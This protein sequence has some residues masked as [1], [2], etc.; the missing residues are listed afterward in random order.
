MEG[1]I[2]QLANDP[3]VDPKYRQAIQQTINFGQNYLNYKNNDGTPMYDADFAK[4]ETI[5]EFVSKICTGE[6]QITP[7]EKSAWDSLVSI[8]NKLG[9]MVGFNV[10]LN[11]DDVTVN[12][13]LEFAN[14]LNRAFRSGNE[15][16]FEDAATQLAEEDKIDVPTTAADFIGEQ[17]VYNGEKG[18]LVQDEGGKITFETES[19]IYDL[20]GTEEVEPVKRYKYDADSNTISIGDKNYR[21]L[22][23]NV[24]GSY[25]GGEI[26]FKSVNVADSNNNKKT[27]RDPELARQVYEA[28][29]ER[30]IIPSISEDVEIDSEA[31]ATEIA[32][33]ITVDNNVIVPARA[34]INASNLGSEK[35]AVTEEKFKKALIPSVS[36][37]GVVSTTIGKSGLK[38]ITAFENNFFQE[39]VDN[40]YIQFGIP[41]LDMN[42]Q[43]GLVSHPDSMMVGELRGV[44][45]DKKGKP[46]LDANKQPVIETI[47]KGSGGVYFATKDIWAFKKKSGGDAF[48]KKINNLLLIA[49]KN[50]PN[51]AV[52]FF[53]GKG[54][55]GKM[56]SNNEAPAA[57]VKIY[58]NLHRGGV[59]SDNVLKQSIEAAL[60]LSESKMDANYKSLLDEAGDNPAKIE[61]AEL[62]KKEVDKRKE[63]NK[64]KINKLISSKGLSIEDILEDVFSE[65]GS[66]EDRGSAI[67]DFL[68]KSYTYAKKEKSVDKLIEY[69][70]IKNVTKQ[71]DFMDEVSK[72]LFEEPV[73]L[74]VAKQHIYAAIKIDSPIEEYGETT[75]LIDGKEV[76]IHTTYKSHVRFQDRTKVPTLLFFDKPFLSNNAFEDLETGTVLPSKKLGYTN[77]PMSKEVKA[78]ITPSM[79]EDIR[80][81]DM[82]SA[83]KEYPSMNEDGMGNYVFYPNI[84][85]NSKA[86][87][88]EDGVVNLSVNKKEILYHGSNAKI[89]KFDGSY[90]KGGLRANYGWGI[91]FTS[92][93]YKAKEYGAETTYLDISNLNVLDLT[94]KVDEF[95]VSKIKE[96]ADRKKKEGAFYSPLLSGQYELIADKFEDHI[97]DEVFNAWRTVFSIFNFNTDKMWADILRGIGYDVSKYGYEY[98][99]FNLDK[100]D[101]YL[102]ESPESVNNHIAR[103]PFEGVYPMDTNPLGVEGETKKEIANNALKL[104]FPVVVRTT[105][106]GKVEAFSSVT[107]P[108]EPIGT[109]EFTQNK[110]RIIPSMFGTPMV[111]V[112]EP[113]EL[114]AKAVVNVQYN[115]GPVRE[116]SKFQS[117]S[118][119]KVFMEYFTPTGG[120]TIMQKE[121]MEQLTGEQSFLAN[122]I[123]ES[124]LSLRK[125]IDSFVN[126]EGKKVGLTKQTV[127]TIVNKAMDGEIDPNT[128]KP[129]LDQLPSNLADAVVNARQTI[130][131]LQEALAN[132][133]L[134]PA[135]MALTIAMSQGTYMKD[136]FAAFEVKP[137]SWLMGKITGKKNKYFKGVSEQ[138]RDKVR[139]YFVSQALLGKLDSGFNVSLADYKKNYEDP[140]FQLLAQDPTAEMAATK[141]AGIA[142]DQ[143]Y[144]ELEEKARRFAQSKIDEIEDYN[145]NGDIMFTLSG[146]PIKMTDYVEKNPNL[147]PE[148]KEYLG[149][150]VDPATSYKL[151]AMKLNRMLYSHQTMQQMK[152]D[153]LMSGDVVPST[154]ATPKGWIKLGKISQR[155]SKTMMG[156]AT[157]EVDA[158]NKYGPLKGCSVSPE[159]YQLVFNTPV[160][161]NWYY[162][163][164]ASPVKRNLAVVNIKNIIR[165]IWGY[166]YFGG[167]NGAIPEAIIYAGPLMKANKNKI[168]T[169]KEFKDWFV[170][171]FQE[172]QKRG[173]NTSIEYSEIRRMADQLGDN[174]EILNSVKKS[175]NPAFEVIKH[176]SNIVSNAPKNVSDAFGK[177]IYYGDAIPKTLMF[178]LFRNTAAYDMAA[179]TFYGLSEGQK[180]Q[181]NRIAERKV[182]ATTVTDS[183]AI[184]GADV[185]Q[186]KVGIFGTFPRFTAEAIRTFINCHYIMVN[187]K[188]LYEGETFS[189]NKDQDK[190]IKSRMNRKN[191]YVALV[192]LSFYWGAFDMIRTL[193]GLGDDD[194]DLQKV[195]I[196]SNGILEALQLIFKDDDTMTQSEALRKM[197]P[198]YDK[199]A[200][201]QFKANEDGTVSYRN[202]STADPFG[203]W[204]QAYRSILYADGPTSAATNL[205]KNVA[206]PALGLEVTFGTA[207]EI[208]NGENSKGDPIYA[209]DDLTSKQFQ[210]IAS[211]FARKTG[212]NVYSSGM[213]YRDLVRMG[214]R[215][216]GDNVVENALDYASYTFGEG[217]LGRESIIDVKKKLQAQVSKIKQDWNTDARLYSGEFY[218]TIDPKDRE[219]INE[220]R[221]EVARRNAYKLHKLVLAA[222]ALNL[223]E[224]EV[225]EV[226]K[227]SAISKKVRK[228]ALRGGEYLDRLDV[229]DIEEK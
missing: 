33:P 19:R 58:E 99:V 192:G 177:V 12:N 134:L 198:E 110:Q 112:I 132:S 178:E 98:V 56:L 128:N 116:L 166:A 155:D 48:V 30:G 27:L 202:E 70:G 159:F 16:S 185:L 203:I 199:F 43:I 83:S 75:E 9:I 106:D 123:K 78:R 220:Q 82:V 109:Q 47:G 72:S 223:S 184:K 87:V 161:G 93:P 180:A 108:A 28:T 66:F 143:A 212:P 219:A 164:I 77:I 103:V 88:N 141:Q 229:N 119:G 76:K 154:E 174:E 195:D 140:Y 149:Y 24:Q 29:Q 10:R 135:D 38:K 201:L 197:L 130:T 129:F 105:E 13:V 84:V 137:Y 6:I 156:T 152:N 222:Y 114:G 147:S 35:E 85:V 79:S 172:A 138:T 100:A 57:V 94:S 40:G 148:M 150:I 162:Q 228:A 44:I 183:R 64:I 215:E 224:A 59:I 46:K 26:V 136:S 102:V 41:S 65:N 34:N 49:K 69:F 2:R 32:S 122:K 226:F 81:N 121:L 207:L 168:K 169:A 51:A 196:P 14:T 52:Y 95:F 158:V 111:E 91:Y 167:A 104:G 221:D 181:A 3:S 50:D 17:V 18:T 218:R 173:I 60:K 31:L 20:D 73:L 213:R 7:K 151:T 21:V 113:G 145:P 42:N 120:S 157:D 23:V 89:T 4:N 61:K 25:P 176:V 86:D 139:N 146:A 55:P 15:I 142:K 225:K 216:P 5:V 153:G 80:T 191:R 107:I 96:L 214:K 205:V 188:F 194:E 187:P 209:P 211:Y 125:L 179:T 171:S 11:S 68:S 126:N 227:K 74:D 160:T 190:K 175:G 189:S 144:K 97:G 208:F 206:T 200:E 101:K 67:K 62:Y 8:L 54:A 63:Q 133:G 204:G 115:A 124:A 71:E 165:N 193:M 39:L 217:T 210:D 182:K 92:S 118:L 170:N 22:N 117:T 36:E 37:D 127:Q 45:L 131:N 163:N 1:Q 53:L 186:R 90:I